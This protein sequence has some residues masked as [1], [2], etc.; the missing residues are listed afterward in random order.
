MLW[1][2]V[3]ANK[4][5]Q[6]FRKALLPARICLFNKFGNTEPRKSLEKE[7]YEKKEEEQRRKKFRSGLPTVQICLFNKFSKYKTKKSLVKKKY[8]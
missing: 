6:S 7:I 1:K 5:K 8:V 2:K 4:K 3:K